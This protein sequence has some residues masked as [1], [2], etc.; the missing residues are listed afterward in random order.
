[1]KLL[2]DTQ[3]AIWALVKR[4]RLDETVRSLIQDESNEVF[5]SAASVWEIAIKY[6]LRKRL[7]APPFGGAEALGYFREAGYLL[8]SITPEHATAV[9]RLPLVHADP[10]DRLL[11]AQALNE[12]MRLI[13]ADTT[14]ASYSD[15]II[16]T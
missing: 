1:V 14:M 16:I 11:I 4:S 9:E 5:V 3:I 2:L 13:T 12:P 10:F 7:G 6:A 8:L 15:T